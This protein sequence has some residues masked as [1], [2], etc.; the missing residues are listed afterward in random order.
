MFRHSHF[1]FGGQDAWTYDDTYYIYSKKIDC[2]DVSQYKKA[3]FKVNKY[4]MDLNA[5]TYRSN[6]LATV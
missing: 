4:I 3:A 5:G 2:K 1:L 6:R